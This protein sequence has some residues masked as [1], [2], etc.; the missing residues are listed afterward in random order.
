MEDGDV[1][2]FFNKEEDNGKEVFSNKVDADKK[3]GG[4]DF[5]EHETYEQRSLNY[6]M[7][8]TTMIQYKRVGKIWRKT[9]KWWR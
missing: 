9:E 6:I 1:E 2:V 4:G 5:I 8:I 3:N 7:Y